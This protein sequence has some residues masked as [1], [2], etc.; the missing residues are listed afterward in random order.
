MSETPLQL[1][2][3]EIAATALLSAD[4]EHELALGVASGSAEARDHLIRANLRLVVQIARSFC[5]RGLPLEDLIAEGNLGLVRAAEG[6]DPSANVRFASYAR[7]WIK[8]SIRAALIKYGKPVR[9]PN[10][11]ISQLSKWRR[12]S[13]ALRRELGREP[14]PQEVGRVLKLSPKKLSA[15]VQAAKVVE[16]INGYQKTQAD[17]DA[18]EPCDALSDFRFHCAEARA[19]EME[20]TDALLRGLATLNEREAAVV[21]MR[22]GLGDSTPRTLDNVS[23]AL[24]GCTREQ[25]RQLEKRALAKLSRRVLPGPA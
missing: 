6:F 23:K 5:G 21:R 17:W 18:P 11:M 10:Y 1:Y 24:G 15:L 4:D 12:A 13:L 25:T 19:I 2:L 14:T 9:L 16:V 8:Q 7:Y 22:F 20:E 3:Q